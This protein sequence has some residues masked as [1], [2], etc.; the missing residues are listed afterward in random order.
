MSELT[1][2]E[3]SRENSRKLDHLVQLVE[4][5]GEDSPGAIGRISI[6][7]RIVFGK[8]NHGGILQQ[9]VIMWRIHVWLLCTASGCLGFCLKWGLDKFAKP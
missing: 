8:E 4:G 2:L 6:L 7:E 1:A 3:I 9:H 5:N